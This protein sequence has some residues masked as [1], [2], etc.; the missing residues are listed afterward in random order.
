MDEKFASEILKR[1]DVLGANITKNGLKL[2]EEAIKYTWAVSLGNLII[3][4]CLIVIGVF[5]LIKIFPR[6]LTWFMNR[7]NYVY[8][9]DIH[10][11]SIFL[12][13]LMIIPII[14]ISCLPET[15][16]ALVSPTWA[17][18]KNLIPSVPQ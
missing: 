14:A 15:I 13:F 10:F 1:L 6:Y 8:N 11:F 17:A 3:E 9:N 18:V 2:G 5:C 16:A 12:W 4:I 7:D